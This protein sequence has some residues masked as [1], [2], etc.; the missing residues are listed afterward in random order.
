[1]KDFLPHRFHE[2]LSRAV[3]RQLSP[4]WRLPSGLVAKV[5]S[6]AEWAIYNDIFVE[7]EY[8]LAISE[9]LGNCPE[10]PVVVDLGANVGYFALRFAD[11]WLRRN[12]GREFEILGV[13]GSPSTY[14][15]LISRMNQPLISESCRFHLGLIGRR[16]GFGFISNLPFHVANSVA[17]RPSRGLQRV[18]YVGLDSLIPDDRRISLL[19]CDIE[20][21]EETFLQNYPDLLR[22]VDLAV[23]E[24]HP[25]KCSVT[26]CMELLDAAGLVHQTNIR[27]CD[28]FTVD[29]FKRC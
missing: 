14:D 8:D 2:R 25:D 16:T 24:M 6:S 3:W 11:L 29:L 28:S 26:L 18:R 21:S 17:I 20:G 15:E 22:R 7:G 10:R 5:K 9:L 4:V 19:K 1:M 23:F 13:E 27:S 12:D